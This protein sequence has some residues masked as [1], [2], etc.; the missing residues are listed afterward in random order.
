MAR[1]GCPLPGRPAVDQ[2]VALAAL[3]CLLGAAPAFTPRSAASQRDLYTDAWMRAPTPSRRPP[4]PTTSCTSS[5]PTPPAPPHPAWPPRS[6]GLAGAGLTFTQIRVSRGGLFEA[7]P[8]GRIQAWRARVTS[9]ATTGGRDD[10]R[11]RSLSGMGAAVIAV[12]G[13][14]TTGPNGADAIANYTTGTGSG[15]SLTVTM[16]AFADSG[17]RPLAFF[18]HAAS[19][20]QLPKAVTRSCMTRNYGT[21]AMGHQ[22]EW[23][24]TVANNTPSASWTTLVGGG[25]LRAGDRHAGCL[26]GP[27]GPH[28]RLHQGGAVRVRSRRNFPQRSASPAT[29]SKTRA[30]GGRVYSASGFDIEFRDSGGVTKLDHEIEKYDGTAGTLVAWVRVPGLSYDA[31]STVSTS[32]TGTGDHD[33]PV[34]PH[35]GMGRELPGRLAPEGRPVRDGS[36]GQEQQERHL[37]RDVAGTMTNTDQV[38]GRIDGSLDFD[39]TDDRI[40]VGSLVG[41]NAAY[42][43]SLWFKTS[44]TTQFHKMWGEGSVGN[45][46]PHTYLSVNEAGVAGDVEFGIRD[47]T[48]S[49][50]SITHVGPGTTT[51]GTT[52]SACRPAR[53]AA[54]SSSTEARG[55]RARPPWGRSR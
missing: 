33:G 30:N 37:R 25:R 40:D 51:P 27:Q 50:G 17:H 54:S 45:G 32:T 23:H 28:H 49:S 52:S 42:T 39:G 8:G 3:G 55:G 5:T 43:V 31:P 48:F 24:A 21:P 15:T 14:R 36:T 34:E 12:T 46:I 11:G 22:A 6:R 26:R 13:A 1:A 9:G 7:P 44:S 4:T 53:A 41:N 29:T 19:Q 18:S 20:E 10:H 16:P 47:D 38:A 2:R 35:R